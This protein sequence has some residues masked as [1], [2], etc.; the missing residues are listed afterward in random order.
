MAKPATKPSI[1]KFIKS[2]ILT[3]CT[4]GKQAAIDAGYSEKTAD[5]QA[6]RLL[7]SV[8]V[9]TAVK[10]H[11]EKTNSEFTYSKDKKLK[12]LEDVMTA[13]K[14]KD[15]EK[16]VINATAVIAAVKEHNM[17]MGHNA[18]T[19][20]VTNNNIQKVQIEVIGAS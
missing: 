13:C 10:E 1:D 9:L 17:M 11:Q 14:V 2:Y 12:I 3:G 4:N 16:G 20:I 8:K 6:S 5:Q 7:K 18:P 19:E 15:A